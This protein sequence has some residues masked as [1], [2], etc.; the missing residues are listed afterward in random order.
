MIAGKLEMKIFVLDNFVPNQP[1]CLN[2]LRSFR[3]DRVREIGIVVKD[4]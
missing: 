3:E 1:K 2:R 4:R